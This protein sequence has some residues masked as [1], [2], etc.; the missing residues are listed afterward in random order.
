MGNLIV[1]TGTSAIDLAKG[2]IKYFSGFLKETN[3]K[4]NVF[5][6]PDLENNN[7]INNLFDSW[8]DVNNIYI[9]S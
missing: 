9:L 4:T 3:T 7:E 1:S 5:M 2:T 8:E 6:M